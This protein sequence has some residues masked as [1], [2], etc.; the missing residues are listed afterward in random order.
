MLI[1][2]RE[3]GYRLPTEAFGKVRELR[4]KPPVAVRIEPP[5]PAQSAAHRVSAELGEL[6]DP[7]QYAPAQT[8]RAESRPS[9]LETAPKPVEKKGFFRQFFGK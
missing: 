2:A 7:D 6:P 4:D 8:Q 5:K 9:E 3:L 1:D